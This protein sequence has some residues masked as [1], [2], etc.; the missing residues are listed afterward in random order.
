MRFGDVSNVRSLADTAFSE[1]VDVVVSCLASR[2]GGKVGIV[3]SGCH[4]AGIKSE[5]QTDFVIS[6]AQEVLVHTAR[7]KTRGTSTTRRH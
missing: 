5:H 4:A 3:L 6:Q 1:P 7:R 2:T